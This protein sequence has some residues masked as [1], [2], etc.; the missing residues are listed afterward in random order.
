MIS[1]QDGFATWIAVNGP[2]TSGASSENGE[3]YLVFERQCRDALRGVRN[4]VCAPAKIAGSSR[5]FT[6]FRVC[7]QNNLR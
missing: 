4:V 1:S 7:E 3:E 6:R 2:Y 5:A